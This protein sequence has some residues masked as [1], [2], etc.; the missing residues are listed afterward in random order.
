V[1]ANPYSYL[2]LV[3][4]CPDY[5]APP[6]PHYMNTQ[7]GNQASLRP[8]SG[9]TYITATEMRRNGTFD[10][11][12]PLPTSRPVNG[13][14]SAPWGN[15]YEVPTTDAT[16][17]TRNDATNIGYSGVDISLGSDILNTTVSHSG[18]LARE[19]QAGSDFLASFNQLQ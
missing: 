6:T 18:T 13:G 5:P 19:A 17:T 12:P 9:G 4:T 8:E 15:D 10:D 3:P 14:V 7:N 16:L 2:G 1:S 11:M